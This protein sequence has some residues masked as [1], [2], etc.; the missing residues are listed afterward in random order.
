MIP[1]TPPV[2]VDIVIRMKG[3]VNTTP[4]IV[5]IKRKNP[6]FGWALPGG[7]VDFGETVEAAALREAREETGLRV[8]NLRLMGV[9]SDPKRDPRGHCVSIVFSGDARGTPKAGD[10]A[11]GIGVYQIDRLIRL[12]VKLAFDHAKILKQYVRMY[13]E[14]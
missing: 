5:L 8:T 6:P 1:K 2:T 4:G 3:N 12:G 9:Y 7:F 13:G 10:D 14:G 11:G